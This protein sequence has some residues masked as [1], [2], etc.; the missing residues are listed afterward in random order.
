MINLR[1]HHQLSDGKLQEEGRLVCFTARLL[2]T[3]AKDKEDSKDSHDA[4]V[5]LAQ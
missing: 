1:L 4:E 5:I 2:C 3:I